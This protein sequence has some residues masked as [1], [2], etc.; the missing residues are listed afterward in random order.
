MVAIDDD[1]VDFSS[2]GDE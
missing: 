1:F 2:N